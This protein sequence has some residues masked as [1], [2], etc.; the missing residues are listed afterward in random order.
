MIESHHFRLERRFH[1]LSSK[2]IHAMETVKYVLHLIQPMTFETNWDVQLSFSGNTIIADRAWGPF[3]TLF[4]S[5]FLFFFSIS[6]CFK[7][8]DIKRIVH[9]LS[10]IVLFSHRVHIALYR[11][12]INIS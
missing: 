11:A 10:L 2:L 8:E 3:S 4:Y 6:F 9:I 1:N 12:R 7:K 5:N